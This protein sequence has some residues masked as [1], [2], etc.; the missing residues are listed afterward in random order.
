MILFMIGS[1]PSA[2]HTPSSR[3]LLLTPAPGVD[4]MQYVMIVRSESPITPAMATH[5]SGM[6][7]AVVAPQMKRQSVSSVVA[8]MVMGVTDP[9]SVSR[10][11]GVLVRVL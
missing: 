6:R 2:V 1:V 11:K 3:T 9:S 8:M 7:L 10:K 4:G 5:L